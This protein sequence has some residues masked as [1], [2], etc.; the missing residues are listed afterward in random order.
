MIEFGSGLNLGLLG[1]SLLLGLRHGI[2]WDHIAAITDIT[3]TQETPRRGVFLGSIYA[4][5][6][7]AVVL[8]LGVVVTTVGGTIPDGLDAAMGRVVGWTLILLGVYVVVSLIRDRGE[9]RLRSRWMLLFEFVRFV[10]NHL[11]RAF[12]K[13]RATVVHDHTHTAIDQVH[14][15]VGLHDVSDE[16]VTDGAGP[17]KAPAHSHL[18]SHEAASGYGVTT[19]T[20]IGML[21]GIGAETPTQVVIFLA[22][23]N[24]GGIANGLAVLAVFVFGLLLANTGITLASVAGFSAAGHRRSLHVGLGVASATMSLIVGTMLVFGFDS[25]LPALLAG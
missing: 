5:G 25:A 15:P 24:A 8:T 23:A 6:H 17:L 1:A 11:T 13:R 12:G 3:A 20:L 7:A 22:A 18:H 21:H 14:H 16:A 9:M 19:T 4:L 2:D 10:R